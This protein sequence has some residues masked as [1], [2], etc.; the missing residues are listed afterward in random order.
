M[1][2]DADASHDSHAG[3][4]YG[5]EPP[6]YGRR[7]GRSNML[8]QGEQV[9]GFSQ[10]IYPDKAYE[11]LIP[12]LTSRDASPSRHRGPG[13]S[14]AREY[15]HYPQGRHALAVDRNQQDVWEPLVPTLRVWRRR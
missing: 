13:L 3:H 4:D 9:D 7:T 8:L 10:I 15:P 14:P 2:S 11:D 5:R 1:W 12:A 6:R